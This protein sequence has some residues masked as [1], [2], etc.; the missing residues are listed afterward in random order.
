MCATP[1]SCSSSA[2]VRSSTPPQAWWRAPDGLGLAGLGLP[3][4]VLDGEQ[5]DPR[6]EQLEVLPPTALAP[7]DRGMAG[8][9]VEG[10]ALR[11]AVAEQAGDHRR[12]AVDV[13]RP[14][15]VVDPEG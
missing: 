11:V 5:A 4:E 7:L 10:D 13:A 8:V 15:V 6:G 9:E 2:P 12:L 1:T 3:A 14:A